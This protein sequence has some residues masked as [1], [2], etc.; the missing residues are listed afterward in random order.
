MKGKIDNI[1]SQF[2]FHYFLKNKDSF[3]NIK[4]IIEFFLKKD[5]RIIITGLNGNKLHDDLSIN[6]S[7]TMK[8]DNSRFV[9]FKID[10]LY[11][12]NENMK[13]IGQK[14]KVFVIS[15]GISHEEYLINSDFLSKNMSLKEKKDF[16]L[17]DKLN[18]AEKKYNSY[19]QILIFSLFLS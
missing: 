12:S 4:N 8:E 2:S 9:L 1:Y 7:L 6:K 15:I 13:D 3:T 17:S 14:I 5:G 10:R 11:N 19:M 18:N 16:P